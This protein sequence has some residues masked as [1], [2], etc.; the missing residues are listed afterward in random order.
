MK[1]TVLFGLWVVCCVSRHALG[2]DTKDTNLR[3]VVCVF[4]HNGYRRENPHVT[5]DYPI[6]RFY[7]R[8]HWT[9]LCG[10]NG[11]FRC[12]DV[13]FERHSSDS[14]GSVN[15]ASRMVRNSHRMIRVRTRQIPTRETLHVAK[16][17]GS[18]IRI[19]ILRISRFYVKSRENQHRYRLCSEC[20]L[21]VVL[22]SGIVF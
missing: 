16:G 9:W 11:V 12:C 10:P 21:A 6:C 7:L 3:D 17:T 8:W 2:Y 18:N 22:S 15:F 14:M 13:F 1:F 20:S 4:L 19:L 5:D